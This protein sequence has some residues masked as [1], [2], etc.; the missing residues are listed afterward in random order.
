MK[1]I[2]TL[3]KKCP[4]CNS[5][6]LDNLVET[7]A[8]VL[9]NRVYVNR[10]EA[11]NSKTGLISLAFCE[12]C[13]FGFNATFYSEIIVYDQDY[14]NSVPSPLFKKYY[15]EIANYLYRKYN[16]RGKTVYDIG[17][18]KGTFLELMCEK[19]PDVKGIGIDPSYEGELERATNLSFIRDF[20]DARYISSK[21]DLVLSRHVF[22]H[23][24]YPAEFLSI[25]ENALFK[26][27]NVPFFFEVPDFSWIIQ[28]NT[29]WDICYEHCNYFS[30]APLV[31][32][33]KTSRTK[34][35]S[36]TPAFADQY[37]WFEGLLNATDNEATSISEQKLDRA[38]VNSFS[39]SFS[40][41]KS[42]SLEFLLNAKSKGLKIIVW[43]M[44]TKG[45]IF[46]SSID[47]ENV[48]VDYCVDLNVAKQQKFIPISGHQIVA[49]EVL[50]SLNDEH[51]LVIVMNPIYL[52]EIRIFVESYCSTVQ[53]VDAHCELL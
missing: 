22:E 35:T 3:K 34:T 42:Y 1:E 31:T 2:T 7:V 10:A 41:L 40:R 32:L 29:F 24:E 48:I 19:Y 39:E 36:I 12:S 43:G 25:I 30:P 26:Y 4:V 6:K 21:P 11:L 45:V 33:G 52:E 47:P 46:S 23:I 18:G 37:I 51:V 44:A 9:Q 28:H 15:E 17:C 20:F 53:F 14:D 5:D 8:P 50:E 27:E 13:G 16:L 38:L 49:P